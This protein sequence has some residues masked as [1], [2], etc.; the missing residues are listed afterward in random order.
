VELPY[1][2]LEDPE[3]HE[4]DITA[5]AI[6]RSGGHLEGTVT[7]KNVQE[8]AVDRFS[9]A[10]GELGDANGTK[11]PVTFIEFTTQDG[12]KHRVLMGL[13][14][15]QEMATKL[16]EWVQLAEAEHNSKTWLHELGYADSLKT[17]H[18]AIDLMKGEND[19][20]IW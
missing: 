9:I 3:K 7:G 12:G 6:E 18:E 5:D 4:A 14:Q 20:G 10:H 13:H 8:V 17:I 16:L 19:D 15:T 11:W 2:Y 1:E